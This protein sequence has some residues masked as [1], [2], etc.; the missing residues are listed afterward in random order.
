MSSWQQPGQG[1]P[2]QGPV[3]RRQGSNPGMVPQ[4]GGYGGQPNNQY[5]YQQQ[6]QYGQQN[7]ANQFQPQPQPGYR[8]NYS[9]PQPATGPA[10]PQQQHRIFP[11]KSSR[12]PSAEGFQGNANYA[13]QQQAAY[14]SGAGYASGNP[15]YA[16]RP[17]QYQQ[18]P[19]Q[20]AYGGGF[21]NQGYQPQ[22]AQAPS[23]DYPTKPQAPGYGNQA[24]GFQQKPVGAFAPPVQTPG[25]GAPFL[26]S[27]FI[28][29]IQGSAAGQIGMQLGSQALQQGQQ[30]VNQNINRYVNVNTL[31]HYFNVSNSYVLNKIRLLLFPFRHKTWTRLVK[32]SENDGQMEGYKPPREDLN[33]TDMYIPV[34]SFVTYVLLVGIFMGFKA[35]NPTPGTKAPRF[36]P[37]EAMGTT[38]TGAIFLTMIEVLFMKFGCY[39]LNVTSEVPFLDVISYCGYKFIPVIVSIAAKFTQSVSLM[40]GVFA[41]VMIAYG[42]FTLR[43]M[44]YLVLPESTSTVLGPQR[45]RRIYFLFIVVGL[46]ILSS[47]ILTYI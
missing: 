47:F 12:G 24:G 11:P 37:P 8:P 2:G 32:R 9:Q 1:P 18:Q 13:Q 22:T 4:A 45:Q 5:G 19:S 44:K 3:Q 43:S 33:A 36:S 40:Y 26:G 35:Q 23:P 25:F 30:I 39:L 27:Q 16:N 34:M 41:Y 7:N 17:Q 42:L 10:P 14:G 46:Q 29:E 6:Q 28:N 31:K 21:Q 38:A 20:P 15:A